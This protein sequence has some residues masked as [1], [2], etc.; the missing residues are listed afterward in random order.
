MCVGVGVIAN[1]YLRQTEGDA[2]RC[3]CVVGLDCKHKFVIGCG[4]HSHM[5]V[6]IRT[7][8]AFD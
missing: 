4:L 2:S 7:F 6:E 5:S 8:N 1:V 3:H